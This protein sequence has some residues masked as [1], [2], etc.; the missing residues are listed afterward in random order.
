MKGCGILLVSS[1]LCEPLTMKTDRSGHY[2]C[3]ALPSGDYSLICTPVGRGAMSHTTRTV[4]LASGEQAFVPIVVSALAEHRFRVVDH[5]SGA[6]LAVTSLGLF[7][8]HSIE[9]PKLT[10]ESAADS[11]VYSVQLNEAIETGTLVFRSIDDRLGL[12]AVATLGSTSS[13][14]RTLHAL[15]TGVVLKTVGPGEGKDTWLLKLSAAT[16]EV[17][18]GAEGARLKALVPARKLVVEQWRA[19]KMIQSSVVAVAEG[20]EVQL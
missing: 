20:Q 16:V 5:T 15:P 9:S 10:L 18:S 1:Q 13:D 17:L 19:G 4:S 14:Y 3:S 12:C 6:A 2:E 7:T 8:G 11:F